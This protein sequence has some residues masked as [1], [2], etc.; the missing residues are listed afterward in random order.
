[1]SYSP[2]EELMTKRWGTRWQIINEHVEVPFYM[3]GKTVGDQSVL[4]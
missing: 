4:F 1:M 2:L 3:K